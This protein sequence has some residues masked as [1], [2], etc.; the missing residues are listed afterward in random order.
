MMEHNRITT[1]F[2]TSE[3]IVALD[4]PVK[5]QLLEILKKGITSFEELVEQTGKAK[6][7]I[8]VHL[9][10][11]QKLTLIENRTFPND[12]RKKYFVLNSLYLAYSEKPMW[13]HYDNQMDTFATSI[14][15]GGT[16]RE[17]LFCTIR[18]GMEA[19]GIDPNPLL[20]KLGTDFGTKIM[21]GFKSNDM[22]GILN[23]LSVFWKKHNMG[24]MSIIDNYGSAVRIDSCHHCCK[25]PNVGKKLCSMDEGII[26]SILSNRLGTG[27]YVQET[28]CYGTGDGHCTFV[29]E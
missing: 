25:M 3:G 2:A 18:F 15:N 7:T 23:E 13:E 24:V 14:L 19:Y 9:N 26:E 29:I 12:K 8:S 27:Y 4:S 22:E 1:I 6:S 5:L 21:K 10:D 11:L 16:F 17:N 20:R 28:E